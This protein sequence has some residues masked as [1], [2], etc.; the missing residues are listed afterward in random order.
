[1]AESLKLNL[2]QAECHARLTRLQAEI[3]SMPRDFPIETLPGHA[4][5]HSYQILDQK[6]HE[7][8]LL[9]HHADYCQIILSKVRVIPAELWLEIFR[10]CLPPVRFPDA[11]L[12]PLL[13][14]QIC[15]FWRRIAL[16]ASCLWDSMTLQSGLNNSRERSGLSATMAVAS[17][18]NRAIKLLSKRKSSSSL[19]PISNLITIWAQRSKTRLLSCT[20]QAGPEEVPVGLEP[21]VMRTVLSQS[22]SF[23]DLRLNSLFKAELSLLFS[24][25]L[26]GRHFQNLETLTLLMPD[27]SEW[28]GSKLITAWADAP[29]LRKVKL[30]INPLNFHRLLLPWPQLTHLNLLQCPLA[31]SFLN[32]VLRRCIHLQE[33]AFT[34][35]EGSLE[36]SF[37]HLNPVSLIHLRALHL[38]SSGDYTSCLKGLTF[39]SLTNL[40][41]GRFY[42]YPGVYFWKDS[43]Y[44]SPHLKNISHLTLSD[45]SLPCDAFLDLLSST[46]QVETLVIDMGYQEDELALLFTVLTGFHGST[47]SLLPKLQS[48]TLCVNDPSF[49]ARPFVGM[50]KSRWLINPISSVITRIRS[51]TLLFLYYTDM[52]FDLSILLH[53]Y[54]EEGLAFSAHESHARWLD[55]KNK[56]LSLYQ[57]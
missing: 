23:R 37:N 31:S 20:V 43:H 46:L 36:R 56:K 27:F 51:V 14:C 40:F 22:D 16:Q 55:S 54:I 2:Y 50:I 13:L 45:I 3:A 30:F 9:Q 7:I 17:W 18:A 53:T 11:R 10:H 5:P 26:A 12:A 34:T 25:S 8:T 57:L 47:S 48:L 38:E 39:P 6:H 49:P 4:M 33:G 32:D 21:T 1:L 15:S 52:I 19:E 41:L 28:A 42:T 35:I 29:C 24:Y 44:I